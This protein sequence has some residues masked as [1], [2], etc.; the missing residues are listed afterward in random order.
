M[1][2][3]RTVNYINEWPDCAKRR[4]QIVAIYFTQNNA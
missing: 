3:S 1:Q 2:D 4:K